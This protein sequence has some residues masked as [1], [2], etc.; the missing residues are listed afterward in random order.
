MIPVSRLKDTSQMMRKNY[1][2]V[3]KD[4]T[5][6]SMF[7]YGMLRINTYRL[8]LSRYGNLDFGITLEESEVSGG[9]AHN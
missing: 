8:T 5:F 4:L 6:S 7:F 2:L 1:V 3:I 9:F